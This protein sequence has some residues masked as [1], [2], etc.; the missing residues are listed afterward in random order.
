[1][2]E[3]IPLN[4]LKFCLKLNI[5]FKVKKTPLTMYCFGEKSGYGGG[6]IGFLEFSWPPANNNDI[7]ERVL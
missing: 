4:S 6:V 5:H 7:K 2:G 3:P 1:M